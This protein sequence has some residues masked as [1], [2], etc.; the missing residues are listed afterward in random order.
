MYISEGLLQFIWQHRLIRPGQLSCVDGRQMEIQRPG[1]LNQHAGPDFSHARIVISN[2][3]WIGDVEVH[4]R[5]SDWLSHR[6]HLNAAYDSVILHVVYDHD[7]KILRQDGTE[8]PVLCLR[9]MFDESLSY[10]YKQLIGAASNFPCEAL[11]GQVPRIVIESTL[12]R[13]MVTRL[14]EKSAEILNTLKR[15]KGDWK[16]TFYVTLARNFGFNVNA[17]PFELLACS[18]PSHIL[19]RHANQPL[20]IEALIFGQ[21]GFLD[22]SFSEDYPARLRS[23]YGF[24]K[25]KYQ[26]CSIDKSLWKFLRMRPHSFPTIRLAQFS[27]CIRKSAG[28]FSKVTACRDLKTLYKLFSDLPVDPYWRTHCHF[29]KPAAERSL[30]PG[31]GSVENIAI[32]TCCYVLFAFGKHT[33][34]PKYI[35]RALHFLD[36]IQPESNA[37]LKKYADAGLT[38]DNAF[39][40]QALLQLNKYYCKQKKCLNCGIGIKI[41]KQ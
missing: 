34:Q 37:I 10:K 40:S 39:E 11:I 25:T 6:H 17:A 26:L 27:A 35:D 4:T 23:M 9:G 33:S 29:G 20:E 3:L 15:T 19:A 41:L 21:A 13:T 24:L 12:A 31:I 30:Q 38:P 5:S 16:E 32:N 8:I 18:L 22:Q 14:E 2:T 36:A 1:M 7:M 28:I